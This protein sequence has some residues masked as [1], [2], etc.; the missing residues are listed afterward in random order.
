VVRAIK[1]PS[2]VGLLAALNDMQSVIHACVE[3]NAGVSQIV[4]RAKDVVFVARRVG[5]LQKSRVY[6]LARRASSGQGA[7]ERV[8]V[9]SL[10]G[11]R[12]LGRGP[13]GPLI[14][15]Q[16]FEHANRGVKRRAG[17][18]RRFAVPTAIA[19][20]FGQETAGKALGQA[21]EVG[22]EC[23]RASIDARL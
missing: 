5:K 4:E 17:A 19:E 22:A 3:L 15:E 13:D 8:L 9:A 7:L 2:T 23:E 6:E 11:G 20:L 14:L 10:S 1:E 16:P 18:F 12:N 21:P